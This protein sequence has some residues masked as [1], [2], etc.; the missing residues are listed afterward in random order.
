MR[1]KLAVMGERTEEQDEEEKERQ[2]H[3]RF[4]RRFSLPPDADTAH[5]TAEYDKGVLTVHVPRIP[6]EKPRKVEITNDLGPK[7][8]NDVGADGKLESRK[9][10]FGYGSAAQNI[11]ALQNQNFLAGA[12]EIGGVD[13]AVVAATNDNDVVFLF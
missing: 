3:G 11:A 7:Q 8:R 10:F 6:L 9:D 2:L 5:V 1:A 13:K 12:G 4:E